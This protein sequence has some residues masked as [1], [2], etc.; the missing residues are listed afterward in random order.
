MSRREEEYTHTL[1]IEEIGERGAERDTWGYLIAV[2][3]TMI[4]HDIRAFSERDHWIFRKSNHEEMY[5][6]ICGIA[7]KGDIEEADKKLYNLVQPE[8]I[9][10]VINHCRLNYPNMKIEIEDRTRHAKK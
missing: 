2:N 7:D 10:P 5:E 9:A 6:R 8:L 1:R 4:V 3:M